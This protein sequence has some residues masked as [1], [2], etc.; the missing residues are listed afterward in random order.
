ME[1]ID[2]KPFGYS[3]IKQMLQK[4]NK[5]FSEIVSQNPALNRFIYEELFRFYLSI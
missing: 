1:K 5:L 3:F 2:L 4:L